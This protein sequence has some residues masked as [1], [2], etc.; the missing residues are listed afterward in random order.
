M[1]LDEIVG[2]EFVQHFEISLVDD[3]VVEATGQPYGWPLRASTVE[4]FRRR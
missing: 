1:V 2:D 4:P 3:F